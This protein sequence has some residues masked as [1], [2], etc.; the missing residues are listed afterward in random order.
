M[1]LM[2]LAFFMVAFVAATVSAIAGFGSALIL[3]SASS[4]FFDIKW[5]IAMT[6]FF[7]GY[8]TCLKTYYFRAHIDWPLVFKLSVLAIPGVI[9][10][11]YCLLRI[12][13]S[14]LAIGLAVMTFIYLILDIFK[15]I[16]HSKVNDVVLVISGF[17]YG[18]VSGA[19][20]TGS[21]VK[22]MVFKQI[23]LPKNAFVACMAASALPLNIIKIAIFIG[24]SLVVWK[25]V[26]SI[27]VLLLA[28]Y[29]GTLFGKS[30]LP[31][32]SQ[33]WFDTLVRLMLFSL[34]IGLIMGALH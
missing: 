20:G 33:I 1:D 28:S 19:V 12:D 22:A 5:S 26:P 9:I 6:T 17:I 23:N 11:A 3:I 31:K 15:L 16:P 14:W 29:L 18:F 10:G 13:A 30:L 27:F 32:V 4:L 8:N 34:S 24:A 21:I 2:L 7:Y 25:D